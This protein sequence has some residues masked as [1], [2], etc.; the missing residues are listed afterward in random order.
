MTPLVL[1]PGLMCDGRLFGPQME[2]GPQIWAPAFT[3][4][5]SIGAI[6]D[7]VLAK[8]PP[9]F[10][11]GGLSMGGIVAMEVIARAPERVTRLAL[12]DTNPLAEAPEI[13]AA[14]APQIAAARE[15]R[16]AQVMREELKPNYLARPTPAILDLCLDMALGL[17]PEVFAR[18]SRALQ[19]RPDQSA[20][21][22]AV[23]VPTL[24]LHGAQDRLCPPA[25][26]ELLRD[27]IPGAR[28]VSITGA[29]HLPTLEAPQAVTEALRGWLTA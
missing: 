26:H 24:V 4:G 22:R 21:L 28:L 5:D 3:T 27:L 19:T 13:A 7:W 23:R 6:A 29:G 10:A 18:Q 25:R 15:G 9:R 16:L 17:G 2:L 1:L 11:L 12:M 14:R 8:A 20:G